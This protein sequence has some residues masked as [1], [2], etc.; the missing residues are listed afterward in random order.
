M[1][2]IARFQPGEVVLTLLVREA[3]LGDLHPVIFVNEDGDVLD[4]GSEGLVPA[5]DERLRKL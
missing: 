2:D 1:K 3:A 4:V 5:Q